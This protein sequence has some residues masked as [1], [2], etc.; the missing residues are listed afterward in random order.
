MELNKLT[1]MELHYHVE[2]LQGRYVECIDDDRLEQWPDFFTENCVYKIISRENHDRDLPATAI[3]CDSKGMLEDRIVSLRNANVYAEHNY[4][5]VLSNILIKDL[6][7]GV[8]SV[9]S[10]YLV[11]QTKTDGATEIYNAGKYVDKIVADGDVLKFQEK[12][13]I[14]DTHQIKSLLVTPI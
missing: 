13:A 10:N 2:R 11:M 12:I 1:E 5:H 8:I 4:R 7:D 6:K 9:Q 14:F 3:F